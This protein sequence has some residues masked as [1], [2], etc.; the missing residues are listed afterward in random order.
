MLVTTRW[1]HHPGKRQRG[2]HADAYVCAVIIERLS[3]S[4]AVDLLQHDNRPDAAE[5]RDRS[6]TLRARLDSLAT[7]FADG[8]LT[9]SQ[10]RIA[11]ERIRKQ[12]AEID[13]LLADLGKVNVLG[14]LAGV[15]NVGAIWDGV[16]LDRQRAVIDALMTIILH[17]P[18]RGARTF[19][20]STI[21]IEWTTE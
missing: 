4:D 9:A 10:L 1:S 15:P 17:P 21:E 11:T 3:R 13:D 7:D 2:D 8:E 6:L 18:G 14:G 20:A 12:I 5:L 19:D 16:G